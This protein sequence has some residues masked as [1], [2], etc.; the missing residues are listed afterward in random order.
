MNGQAPTGNLQVGIVLGDFGVVPILDFALHD[1]GNS[2]SSEIKVGG[3]GDVVEKG[4][5]ADK[6]GEL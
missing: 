4:D 5:G 2:T 1:L 3:I 6:D